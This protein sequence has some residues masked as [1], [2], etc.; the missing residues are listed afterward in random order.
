MQFDGSQN[1]YSKCVP[2][3]IKFNRTCQRS[4]LRKHS[5][6]ALTNCQDGPQ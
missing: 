3:S 4:E 1:L 5:S 2:Y 6:Y